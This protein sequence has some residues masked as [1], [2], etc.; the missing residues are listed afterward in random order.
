MPSVSRAELW[1]VYLITVMDVLNYSMVFPLVP[2]IAKQFGASAT[3]ASGIATVYAV[4]QMLSTPTM[5]QLSDRFGRRPILLVSLVGT[6]LSSFGT[7]MAGSFYAL[8]AARCVNG[9]SGSTIGVVSAYLADVTTKEEKAV[10]M[11]HVSIASSVG[12]I[13]GPAAGGLLVRSGFASACYLSG[14]LSAVNLAVALGSL[15]ESRWQ[16]TT[17][18]DKLLSVDPELAPAKCEEQEGGEPVLIPSAANLLFVSGFFLMLGFAAMESILAYYLMDTFFDGHAKASGEFYGRVFAC[19]GAVAFM[20]AF[21]Y[22]GVRESCGERLLLLFGAAVRSLGF[23]AQAMA[24]TELCFVA[25]LLAGVCGNQFIL[26]TTSALLTKMCHKSAYGRCLGIHQGFQALA[27][28][29]APPIFGV[30]YDHLAHTFS[31][32]ACAAS[33]LVAVA[34]IFLAFAAWDVPNTSPDVAD[35]AEPCKEDGPPRRQPEK[36][37]VA[38]VA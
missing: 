30:A 13:L 32:F 26:P 7:G 3:A 25:A 24:T 8:L 37:L 19:V 29:V 33:T 5:G 6:T 17:E 15:K 14:G 31:F 21:V 10:Y 28:V 27:R 23:V 22:K 4:C 9:I 2:S 12:V 36:P 18:S 1:T 38:A 34:C 35:H 11:S 20:G 16:Q